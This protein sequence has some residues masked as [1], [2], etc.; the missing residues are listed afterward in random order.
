MLKN[1]GIAVEAVLPFLIYLGIGYMITRA[2]MADVPFMNRL[3]GI[4][5]E[6]I[7]P[8]LMFYNIYRA[9]AEELVFLSTVI[10]LATVFCFIF[11]IGQAGLLG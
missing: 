8:V 4:T 1:F 2:R 11:G 10:S 6:V 9:S 7:F 3:N 5:F